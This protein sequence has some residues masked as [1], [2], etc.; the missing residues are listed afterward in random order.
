MMRRACCVT[1]VLG[2]TCLAASL[3]WAC[4]DPV[5]DARVAALG[6]ERPGVPAGPNHRPGQPCLACHG[7]DGPSDVELAVA[8]YNAGPGAVDRFHG[9]PPFAETR[10]YVSRV[11]AAYHSY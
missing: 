11:V 2:G 10:A 1:L 9:I 5:H 4:G 7:G 6:D 3:V 8:A